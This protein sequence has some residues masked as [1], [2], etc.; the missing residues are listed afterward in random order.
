MYP[1]LEC[2]FWHAI[3]MMGEGV[4]HQFYEEGK[5]L[6]CG[7]TKSIMGYCRCHLYLIKT[8]QGKINFMEISSIIL[9]TV[10]II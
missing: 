1:S 10:T 9:L 7:A 2:L 3:N 8:T 6:A 4:D 5:L